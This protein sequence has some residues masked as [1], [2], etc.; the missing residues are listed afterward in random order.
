MYQ[1]SETRFLK[2]RSEDKNG[3]GECYFLRLSQIKEHIS[4]FLFFVC[5]SCRPVPL[6]VA[7][8]D[9]AIKQTVKKKRKNVCRIS[10]GMQK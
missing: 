3:F 2:V 8:S 10:V 6:D 4:L 9:S 7:L 5:F 1:K